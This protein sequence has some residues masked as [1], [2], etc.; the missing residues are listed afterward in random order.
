MQRHLKA[1]LKLEWNRREGR[2]IRDVVREIMGYSGMAVS[3][4]I[5]P[6]NLGIKAHI[7]LSSTPGRYFRLHGRFFTSNL[8][9]STENQSLWMIL[10]F[11][12]VSNHNIY[13]S[14][15]LGIY[16]EKTIIQKDT[17]TP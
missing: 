3:L 14:P 15:G 6:N 1:F 4:N 8:I 9:G 10:N 17:C 7:F 11:S 2:V 12:G 13:K 5:T 16:L